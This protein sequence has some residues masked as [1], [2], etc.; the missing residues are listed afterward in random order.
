M[1]H[2]PPNQC[3]LPAFRQPR[4]CDCGEH[5]FVGLTKGQVAFISVAMVPVI[6]GVAWFTL[7]TGKSGRAYAASMDGPRKVLLHRRLTGAADGLVVDHENRDGLDCR[8]GNMRVCSHGENLRNQGI[9]RANRI[10]MK[11]VRVT[12]GGMFRAQITQD[13]LQHFLGDFPTVEE[14]G[15]AYDAAALRLHGEFALTNAALGLLPQEAA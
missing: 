12:R 9:R 15:R 3:R 8:D 2:Y 11:G 6:D 10:G 7:T 13:Y 14:A 4:A 1:T 5:G